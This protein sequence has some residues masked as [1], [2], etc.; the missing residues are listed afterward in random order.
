MS[1][2]AQLMS[3]AMH[4]KLVSLVDGIKKLL[5]DATKKNDADPNLGKIKSAHS[6]AEKL[7]NALKVGTATTE[8]FNAA[9][10]GVAPLVKTAQEAS[11]KVKAAP[12]AAAATAGGTVKYSN[13]KVKKACKDKATQDK[14]ASILA[15]GPS[16]TGTSTPYLKAYHDHVTNSTAVAYN[17]AGSDLK[18]VAYGL[19]NN[20]S[21]I[22]G[23]GG[24]DWTQ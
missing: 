15:S 10:K 7:V 17:W 9:A 2:T 20:S 6:S 11:A 23:A 13:D 8:E 12:K 1:E 4:Q 16:H 22:T 5:D 3:D 21:K 24:Y 18:V 14:I 19:K